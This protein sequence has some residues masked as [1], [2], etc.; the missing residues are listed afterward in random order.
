MAFGARGWVA[1]VILS[2][3]A[4]STSDVGPSEPTPPPSTRPEPKA[5]QPTELSPSAQELLDRIAP[6]LSRSSEGLRFVRSASGVRSMDLHGRFAHA[7]LAV[8]G[9]DGAVRSVCVETREAAEATLRSAE[10]LPP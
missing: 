9:P 1:V 2:V 5:P 7:T 6:G 10:G 3:G 4:C 8:R